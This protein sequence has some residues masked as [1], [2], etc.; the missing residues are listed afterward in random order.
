MPITT[1]AAYCLIASYFIM[2]RS[3]RKDARSL[4]LSPGIEDAGSSRILWIS[5]ALN[6]LLAIAAPVLNAYYLGSFRRLWLCRFVSRY[7]PPW[8]PWDLA[9]GSGR[10]LS[11]DELVCSVGGYFS[12]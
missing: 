5:G 10:R 2:E 9:A 7:L 1:V 6:M 3:L 8:I 12:S 4:N 11:F